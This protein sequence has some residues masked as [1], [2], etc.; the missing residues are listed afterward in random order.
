MDNKTDTTVDRTYNPGIEYGT[1]AST[2]VPFYPRLLSYFSRYNIVEN[3][4]NVTSY[5]LIPTKSNVASYD[6]A[7]Y[8]LM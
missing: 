1:T 7:F 8:L 5:R 4:C 3:K 6:I 2:N